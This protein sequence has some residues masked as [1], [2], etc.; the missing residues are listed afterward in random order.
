MKK[1]ALPLS[2]ILL[3]FVL[4]TCSGQESPSFFDRLEITDMTGKI[5]KSE[6]LD[7]TLIF[8]NFWATWCRPC[9]QEMPSIENARKILEK[10][11]ITFVAISEE[12]EE[13]I[14]QFIT[15]YD[16]NF[17]YTRFPGSLE[18]FDIQS[19]PTTYILSSR[20]EILYTHVG[21]K[22]WDTEENLTLIRSFLP[23]TS[24]R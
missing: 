22:F 3:W 17:L 13:R 10:D 1:S 24:K 4:S 5:I 21:A 2:P 23:G 12:T 7:A 9:L 20:G 19:V 6:D 18:E 8:V 11:N 14:R 15:L 16:Y